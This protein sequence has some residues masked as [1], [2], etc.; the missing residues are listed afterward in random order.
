MVQ[1]SEMKEAV[2]LLGLIAL[3]AAAVA[4]SLTEFQG[5]DTVDPHG[6][7]TTAGNCSFAFNTTQ[8]G[9]EGIDNSTTFLSTIGVIIGVAVLIFI[10][11][12]AFRVAR[13]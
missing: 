3:I 4:L 5:T 13:R 9:L 7:C 1:L 8:S 2:L 10:I 6:N 11:V 12:G